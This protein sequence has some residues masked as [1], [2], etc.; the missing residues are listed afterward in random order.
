MKTPNNSNGHIYIKV[1][2]KLTMDEK[3]LQ[4]LKI[5]NLKKWES[6]L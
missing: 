5:R 6:I 1:K 4:N 2:A 3:Y